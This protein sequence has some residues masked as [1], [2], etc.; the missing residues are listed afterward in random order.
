MEILSFS[1]CAGNQVLDAMEKSDSIK[2]LCTRMRLWEFPEQYIIEP[3]DGSL[4][5]YVAIS[6]ADGSVN[7]IGKLENRCQCGIYRHI[8]AFFRI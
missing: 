2:K 4:Q 1:S 6:R 3:T 5:S 7:L 8:T